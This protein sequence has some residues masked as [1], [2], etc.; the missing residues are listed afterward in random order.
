M[1][2]GINIATGNDFSTSSLTNGD[3]I[4]CVMTTSLACVN[5]A[6]A[7]SNNLQVTVNTIVIPMATIFANATNICAGTNVTFTASSNIANPTYQWKVNNNNSGSNSNIFTSSTLNNNDIVSCTLLTPTTGCYSL[8]T[9]SSNQISIIVK[10]LLTPTIS[11]TSSDADN[12]LCNGQNVQ[13]S[14][15]AS[16]TGTNPIYQWR[17][18]GINTGTN[19]TSFILQ[20]PVNNDEV[21]CVLTSSEGCLVTNNIQSNQL[22]LE[23]VHVNP[24]IQKNGFIL[25]AIS[26]NAGAIWQW[27]QDGQPIAGANGNNY[28]P[29]IY[30]NYTVTETF[31]NCTNTSTPVLLTPLSTNNIILIYP[32]PASQ[33]LFAQSQSAQIKINA[34]SIYD[35]SG[36]LVINQQFNNANLVQINVSNI[37]NA[38]YLAV[39]DTNNGQF[40]TKFIKQ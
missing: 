39:F 16:N 17:L 5:F 33:L 4:S 11:I 38:I 30:G 28:L 10:P 3:I 15:W 40:K 24:I 2:N 31:K 6:T 37:S 13:F 8:N 26:A 34:V 29:I 12:I 27:N 32:N 25:N 14:A 7:S 20:T 23:V 1:E 21:T 19:T 36:R 35:A 22:I 18:N 9:I